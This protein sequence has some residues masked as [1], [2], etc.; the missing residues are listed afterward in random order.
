MKI[1]NKSKSNEIPRLDELKG[2][3][4]YGPQQVRIDILKSKDENNSFDRDIKQMR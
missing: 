1:N 4:V 2:E 3:G